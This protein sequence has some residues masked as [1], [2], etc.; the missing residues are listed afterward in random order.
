MI[1]IRIRRI[2]SF[3]EQHNATAPERAISPE[4]ISRL[5]QRLMQ[6]LINSGVLIEAKPG[7][8][9]LSYE[10]LAEY[11]TARRKR[12]LIVLAILFL[13]LLVYAILQHNG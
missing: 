3:F 6:R 12:I 10:K 1:A 4:E 9:Y 11:N 7:R 2:I 13:G 5:G 8:Y